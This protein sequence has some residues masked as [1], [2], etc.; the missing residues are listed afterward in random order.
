MFINNQL[1]KVTLQCTLLYPIVIICVN[2]AF[3]T[4]SYWGVCCEKLGIFYK[5]FKWTV[6]GN[7]PISLGTQSVANKSYI[8]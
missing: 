4:V 1:F 2:L 8:T 3:T 5:N 7:S 6:N